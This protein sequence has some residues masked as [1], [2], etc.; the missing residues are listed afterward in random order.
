MSRFRGNGGLIS[1]KGKFNYHLKRRQEH[2][3]LLCI[4]PSERALFLFT[5]YVKIWGLCQVFL[6][7]GVAFIGYNQ[8]ASLPLRPTSCKLSI[9]LI[10]T[11]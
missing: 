2:L 3:I 8:C 1:R 10:F 9:A 5:S 7:L 6:S 4:L 11:L